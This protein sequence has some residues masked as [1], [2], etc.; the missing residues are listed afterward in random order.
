MKI[1]IMQKLFN[2]KIEWQDYQR[3]QIQGVRKKE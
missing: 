3:L 1:K 2:I